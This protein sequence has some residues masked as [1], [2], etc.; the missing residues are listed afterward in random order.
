MKVTHQATGT[1]TKLPDEQWS[2]QTRCRM[3]REIQEQLH[4]PRAK[5]SS[6]QLAVGPDLWAWLESEG[7]VTRCESSPTTPPDLLV[8]EHERILLYIAGAPVKCLVDW[9]LEPADYRCNWFTG[10]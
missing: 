9:S 6:I 8:A 5:P 10:S 4:A 7:H 1:I 3:L 2:A